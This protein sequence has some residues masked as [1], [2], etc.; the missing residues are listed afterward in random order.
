MKKLVFLFLFSIFFTSCS[1]LYSLYIENKTQKPIEVFVEL[2]NEKFTKN[3]RSTLEKRE[4]LYFYKNDGSFANNAFGKNHRDFLKRNQLAEKKYN[5]SSDLKYSIVL[6][7]GQFTN[8]DPNN[9]ISIYPFER[10]YYVQDGKMCVIDASAERK[11]CNY[12]V[13]K[14]E[15][16]NNKQKATEIKELIE[17]E[18]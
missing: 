9:S 6:Q 13:V 3:V 1:P 10:V 7:S 16:L 17:V 12:Q 2:K 11:S 5:F 4:D 18:D 14:Q 8:I 15:K